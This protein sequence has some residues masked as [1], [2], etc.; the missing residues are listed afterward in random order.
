MSQYEVI[1]KPL[2]S[3]WVVSRRETIPTWDQVTPTFN[4][5]FDEV[6]AYASDHGAQCAGPAFDLWH[7]MGVNQQGMDVEACCPIQ[8]P[9]SATDPCQV[10][11]LPGVPSAAC[12]VHRGGLDTLCE[13]H[14]AVMHWVEGNG[15][16]ISGPGREV[17]V[18]YER[19]GNP[20]DYVTEVQYPVERI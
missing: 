19:N 3:Q 4:R 8:S 6:Y 10:Y 1:L 13:A 2:P 5:L 14:Q 17:Y 15:Y 7:D 20:D 12:A 9:I 16:Q 11:E 18:Q